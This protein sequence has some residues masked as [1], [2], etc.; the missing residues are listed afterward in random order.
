MPDIAFRHTGIVGELSYGTGFT[1]NE[2]L[3]P[4]VGAGEQQGRA[5]WR[6]VRFVVMAGDELRFAA[7]TP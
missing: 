4:V 7:A 6:R 3:I 5:R 1:A 2:S